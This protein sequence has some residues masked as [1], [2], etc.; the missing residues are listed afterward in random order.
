[1][2]IKFNLGLGFVITLFVLSACV[3]ST[4]DNVPQPAD[5]NKPS[6][7]VLSLIREV[8]D[9][10]DF[11]DVEF[12]ANTFGIKIQQFPEKKS[13]FNYDVCGFTTPPLPIVTVR[14]SIFTE[15]PWFIDQKSKGRYPCSFDLVKHIEAGRLVGLIGRL[16]FNTEK[17]CILEADVIS[18]FPDASKMDQNKAWNFVLTYY[19]SAS[20][21]LVFI[22]GAGVPARN[23]VAEMLFSQNFN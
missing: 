16:K 19:G 2:R 8:V 3:S 22:S 15:V 17:V 14:Q 9:H 23:C 10:S 5:E 6:V 21:K 20:T 18:K 1:M 13:T 12:L 7:Q 11:S 4:R